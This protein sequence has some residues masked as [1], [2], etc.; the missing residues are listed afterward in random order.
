MRSYRTILAYVVGALLI[1]VP[2]ATWTG[3]VC[4]DGRGSHGW[5]LAME[6][7]PGVAAFV[8]TLFARRHTVLVGLSFA[9]IAA[10]MA[11]ISSMVV[12]LCGI[13]GDFSGVRGAVVI[14][15]I[16]CV[17]SLIP[18]G[19]GTALGYWIGRGQGQGPGPELPAQQERRQ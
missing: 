10:V 16:A 15:G 6:L 7:A 1:A 12:G 11:A 14:G 5:E 19:V 8:S 17:Q 18:A 2:S 4:A 9:L 3:S 13:H